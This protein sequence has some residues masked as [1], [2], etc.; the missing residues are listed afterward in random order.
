MG[1]R[2]AANGAHWPENAERRLVDGRRASRQARRMNTQHETAE[3]V[4]AAQQHP[5]QRGM[6]PGDSPAGNEA[7]IATANAGHSTQ[8]VR[9]AYGRIVAGHSV[10]PRD[11]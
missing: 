1:W 11:P 2:S 5:R 8:Q 9:F 6:E 4:P 3:A 7:A 10:S